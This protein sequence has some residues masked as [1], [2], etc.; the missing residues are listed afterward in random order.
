MIPEK[1]SHEI[2]RWLKDKR[3][4]YIQINFQG[5]KIVN[6]NRYESIKIDF[7]VHGNPPSVTRLGGDDTINLET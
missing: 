1:L 2:E 3:Y 4:G 7:V 6:I 5:G